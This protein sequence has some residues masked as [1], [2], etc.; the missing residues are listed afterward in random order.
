MLILASASPRRRELLAQ[1][2]FNFEVQAAS[3]AEE[4]LAGED[5][6][7]YSMRLAREKAEAVFA[8][9]RTDHGFSEPLVVL[10]ADTIVVC[11]GKL[12]GKP[13]DTPDAC[14]ML[15][16][17]SGRTHQV[18]TGVALVSTAPGAARVETA[19]EVTYVVVRT[20]SDAEITAY[21]ADGE[22][23]DKAG[24][25][26]IQGYAARWIPHIQGCYFNVVGLPL[27]L[28]ASMLEAVGIR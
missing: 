15:R 17:L 12:L 26:A 13:A 24:A 11:Q 6:I 16:M 28:V 1:A 18:V 22:P 25:Y 20:L 7:R 2:G 3:I 19:A 14:R 21:V 10:G 9:R 23:L 8:L 4:P 5:G 27:A